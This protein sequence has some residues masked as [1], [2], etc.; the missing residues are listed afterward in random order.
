MVPVERVLSQAATEQLRSEIAAAGGAEIFAVLSRD[1]ESKLFDQLKVVARGTGVE[2]PAIMSRAAW[3][4]MTVHNHPNGVLRPS[5]ADMQVASVFGEEGI[6]SM[7]VDNDVTH[8]YVIVEP[9]LE[10]EPVAIATEQVTHVFTPEGALSRNLDGFEARDGQVE[11]AAAVAKALNQ[12]ELLTVEAGTGTG[13]SLAYLVPSMLW[14]QTNR[15]RVVIAT[16][17]IALQEQLL[18]KDIPLARSL[19]SDPPHAALIKGRSNYVCLRKLHDVMQH[20]IQLFNDHEKDD[21][22][23]ITELAEW[24][25]S[26]GV[27]DRSDL[28]FLPSHRAWETIQSDADMC[29]GAK[30]PHFQQS[31]FYVSRRQAAKARILIVNQ[32]LLFADLA[33]RQATGNHKAAAV[34]PPYDAVVL[35]EAHSVEDIATDHFAQKVS[36]FGLRMSL[37]KLISARGSSGVVVRLHEL[38]MRVGDRDMLEFMVSVVPQLREHQE[39]MLQAIEALSAEIHMAL[40]PDRHARLEVWINEQILASESLHEARALAQDLMVATNQLLTVARRIR[41]KVSQIDDER[42]EKTIEGLKVE[43]DA[44]ITRIESAI[45]AVRDFADR[46]DPNVIPWV[47]LKRFRSNR[48]EFEY[49]VSPLDVSGALREALLKPY[50]SVVM[51]SATLNLNDNFEFIS[52]RLG[53]MD[54]EERKTRFLAVPS[55]FDYASQ[56]VFVVPKLD[57]GPDQHAFPNRVADHVIELA[58]MGTGGTL[59]LFTSYA[60]LHRVSGLVDG[61]LHRLGIPLLVQGQDHRTALIQRLKDHRGVLLGT[62]SFWEGVD[63]PGLA[64]SKLVITKLPFPQV[65]DPIFAARSEALQKQGQRAF[66]TYALPLAVLKFKQGVGRLIRSRRDRGILMVMDRRLLEK[67]YGGRFLQQ[68]ANYPMSRDWPLHADELPPL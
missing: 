15:K 42:V 59:V 18:F 33:V 20:Q 6:G 3:G 12:G 32:A 27:G 65:N 68:L 1:P 60:L 14:A 58:Q 50:H 2:V 47:Q 43:L 37:G 4:E 63:L 16:K 36:S 17:T 55:P 11:M 35:D 26:H 40:N 8:G 39:H 29:L 22:R 62:D 54:F 57:V 66:S 25:S 9:S 51:T 5:Q 31:P 24:V 56:A 53:L 10:T 52:Q 21:K 13:K 7:I 19:M 41:A 30:C 38:M 45:H 28:P 44:R 49:K 61:A 23:E 46:Y 64:L 67:S 48:L 34:I